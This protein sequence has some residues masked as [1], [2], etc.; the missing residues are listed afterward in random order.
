MRDTNYARELATA[1][2]QWRDSSE[3]RIERLLI[4]DSGE[5]EIRFSWWK[6][7]RMTPRPL[8]LSESDLLTLLERAIVSGVFTDEVRGRLRGL[9]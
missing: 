1:A 2:I 4:K 8:D 3:G 9:L 7:G 5:E 6:D